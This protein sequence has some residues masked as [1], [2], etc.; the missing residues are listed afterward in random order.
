MKLIILI[1]QCQSSLHLSDIYLPGN[2]LVSGSIDQDF[3]SE[4]S[5]LQ[6]IVCRISKRMF[7]TAAL[8]ASGIAGQEVTVRHLLQI[9]FRHGQFSESQCCVFR[10]QGAGRIAGG[11]YIRFRIVWILRIRMPG[12]Q[13]AAVRKAERS[14]CIVH[15]VGEIRGRFISAIVSQ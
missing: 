12:I 5:E 3:G 13:P 8:F 6:F 7:K 4:V 2:G 1:I 10:Q 15:Q 9:R 14:D 11:V